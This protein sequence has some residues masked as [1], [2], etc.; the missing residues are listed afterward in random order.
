MHE[1]CSKL[2]EKRLLAA[3]IDKSMFNSGE[4]NFPSIKEESKL[5]IF[6]SREVVD[7]LT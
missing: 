6:W 5:Y 7:I 2:K 4:V 1:L 3:F